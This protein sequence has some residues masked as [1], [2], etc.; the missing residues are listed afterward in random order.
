VLLAVAYA[1]GKQGAALGMVIGTADY[2]NH[3]ILTYEE[4]SSSLAR[5]VELTLIRVVRGKFVASASVFGVL[6]KGRSAV[7]KD[8][9]RVQALLQ[10]KPAGSKTKARFS[11]SRA[12]FDAAVKGY[13]DAARV[14]VSAESTKRAKRT[15]PR[16]RQR[17]PLR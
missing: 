5:L 17:S 15:R 11:L 6:P 8:L 14:R 13:L 7:H 12:A 9:E 4:A 1:G 10:A 2:I 16:L 3:A